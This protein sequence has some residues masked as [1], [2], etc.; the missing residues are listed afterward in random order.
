MIQQ[1]YTQLPQ[2]IPSNRGRFQ[3]LQLAQPPPRSAPNQG[4]PRLNNNHFNNNNRNYVNS[5]FPPCSKNKNLSF[6]PENPQSR[7][8]QFK[9]SSFPPPQFQFPPPPIQT[10]IS[11]ATFPLPPVSSQ[12]SHPPTSVMNPT[13][14]SAPISTSQI[15]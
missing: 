10:A 9:P 5:S 14:L 15:T 7:Q 4:Q 8:F 6:R 13:P 1:N 3:T 2:R 12:L 11:T